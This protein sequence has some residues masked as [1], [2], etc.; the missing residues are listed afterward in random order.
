VSVKLF[1]TYVTGTTSTDRGIIR[2]SIPGLS[3]EFVFGSGVCGDLAAVD[4]GEDV[5]G[6]LG[7]L[8]QFVSAMMFFSMRAVRV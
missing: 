7:G 2:S 6:G 8:W 3:P 1:R 5:P 4:V